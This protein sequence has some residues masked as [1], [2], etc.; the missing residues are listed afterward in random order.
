VVFVNTREACRQL[1]VHPNTLII[2]QIL[3][4]KTPENQ[5]LGCVAIAPG[6]RTFVTFYSELWSKR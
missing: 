5:R 1:G 2:S 4:A 6:V 3:Y